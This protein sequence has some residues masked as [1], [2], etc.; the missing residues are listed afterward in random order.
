MN[1]NL[2]RLESK[3]HNAINPI[4]AL[5][6]VALDSGE[7]LLD[8]QLESCKAYS[9]IGL[10]QIKKFSS[11]RNLEQ[12]GEFTWGQI[13]P[14][15]EVNK[16]LLTDW[17]SVMAINSEFTSEVKSIFAKN[18]SDEKTTSTTKTKSAK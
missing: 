18:S 2:D 7:K 17:K 8:L 10:S 15:G 16:Q 1:A 5:G 12:I 13:E 3:L 14:I 6:S 9:D 11:I 4:H